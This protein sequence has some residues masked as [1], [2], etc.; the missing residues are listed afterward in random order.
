MAHLINLKNKL[1][2]QGGAFDLVTR[3]W[4]AL[5]R[6]SDIVRFDKIYLQAGK[7][8]QKSGMEGYAFMFFS[9]YLDIH[10]A[11]ED[12]D[13][14]YTEMNGSAFKITDIPSP[15]TL[16]LPE[17]PLIPEDQKERIS[18]W[19]LKVAQKYE[20]ISECLDTRKCD[21][22]GSVIYAPALT[23]YN[24]QTQWDMCVVSG[25]PL[26]GGNYHEFDDGKQALNEYFR[27]Y[28]QV[29]GDKNPWSKD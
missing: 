16:T 10:E 14:G 21:K 18:D 8:C 15:A 12:P 1:L 27:M 28:S 6:Y 17:K 2:K 29:F 7:A 11:I 20:D 3:I 25:Y 19:V 13:A 4:I 5:L 9:R 24:C 26:C 23:C 22:C